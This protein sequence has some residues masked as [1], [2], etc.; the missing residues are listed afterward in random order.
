MNPIQ[1]QAFFRITDSRSILISSSVGF[2]I[3]A[4]TVRLA[5]RML[6]QSSDRRTMHDATDHMDSTTKSLSYLIWM[7]IG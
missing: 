6:G 7:A 2:F 5:N 1:N 3:G 4:P